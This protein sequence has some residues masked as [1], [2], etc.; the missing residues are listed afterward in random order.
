MPLYSPV[1]VV[2]VSIAVE[3][4]SQIARVRAVMLFFSLADQCEAGWARLGVAAVSAGGCV[5][6][7][8]RLDDND[9]LYIFC[10]LKA[11]PS[12]A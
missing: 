3:C 9:F 8:T 2:S 7:E 12:S 10:T 6:R 4:V 11:R 1:V 5:S